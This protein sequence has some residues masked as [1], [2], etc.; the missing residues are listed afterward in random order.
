M[1]GHNAFELGQ[2]MLF[3]FTVACSSKAL[4]AAKNYSFL[5]TGT[6]MTL[7]NLAGG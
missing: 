2:V 5:L 1:L 6:A 7:T 4:N 3:W